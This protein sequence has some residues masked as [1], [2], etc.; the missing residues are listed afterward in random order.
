[1]GRQDDKPSQHGWDAAFEDWVARQLHKMYDDVLA[2][3]VPPE[4][5]RAVDRALG[6]QAPDDQGQVPAPGADA[7]RQADAG[8][9]CASQ[10]A[11]AGPRETPNDREASHDTAP[12]GSTE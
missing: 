5:L 3:E 7:D 10:D 9:A 12:H 1:M 2:E 4:L 11:A 6:A 8:R